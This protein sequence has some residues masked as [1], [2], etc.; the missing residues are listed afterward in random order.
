MLGLSTQPTPLTQVCKTN[1]PC[2][3]YHLAMRTN[4]R[5]RIDGGCYFFTVNLAVRRGNN[6]LIREI[7]ALRTAFRETLVS[8]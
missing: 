4:K 2:L 5:L 7:E 1:S 3:Q 6:L 8:P